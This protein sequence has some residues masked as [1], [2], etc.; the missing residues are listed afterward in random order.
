MHLETVM[1]QCDRRAQIRRMIVRHFFLGLS[2]TFFGT[3]FQGKKKS[4][5]EVRGRW[6]QGISRY[7]PVI[8][9][10]SPKKW[11]LW[12]LY[13]FEIKIIKFTFFGCIQA[14]KLF[15]CLAKSW[16]NPDFARKITEL[17]FFALQNHGD[18]VLCPAILWSM[19]MPLK[20]METQFQGPKNFLKFNFIHLFPIPIPMLFL[21]SLQPFGP[22]FKEKLVF[23]AVHLKI[24]LYSNVNMCYRSPYGTNLTVLV[25]LTIFVFGGLLCK[26]NKNVERI[27]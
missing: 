25:I 18:F 4:Q 17:L 27:K 21:V 11:S 5:N 6:F 26:T 19:T 3:F 14:L 15:L 22:V 2:G 12:F 20:I 9:L 7:R 1:G 24:I 23:I 10:F 8:S 16:S 13:I